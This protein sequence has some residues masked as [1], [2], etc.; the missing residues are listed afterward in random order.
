VAGTPL[1]LYDYTTLLRKSYEQA[2]IYAF[3]AIVLM[4]LFHFRSL[5]LLG[6][7]LL[8]V[9]IG[10]LWLLGFMGWTGV[11]FNPANIMTL[12]LV[13]GIGVTNGVQILNRFA[14]EHQPSVL[15]KSTGKAVLVSGLTAIVG[16]GSLVLASH[17]GIRSLGIVMSVG[18][19]A[20]MVAALTIL[21]ALLRILARRGWLRNV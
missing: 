3:I 5:V 4:V 17:Q 1:E 8:P 18:I 2:A 12:P 7:A 10:A 16:F 20:C 14:E 19:A 21:P 6:L 11:P 9:A 13:L 15:A